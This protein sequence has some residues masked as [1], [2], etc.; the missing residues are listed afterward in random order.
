[1]SLTS[2]TTGISDYATRRAIQQLASKL[3]YDASPTF[4]GLTISGEALSST[5][6][7]QWRTAYSWGDHAGLYD[8]IGTASGEI[9]DHEST[10]DHTLLHNPVTLGT[11]N[12]LTLNDQELSLPTTA[13]PTL[14]GLTLTGM[15]G[16]V[17]TTAGVFSGS[18]TLDDMADGTNY[19]RVAATE[20]SSGVYKN[21]TTTVKGIASFSSTNFSVT[22][23]AVSLATGGGLTHNDLGSLQGGTTGEYYHFTSADYAK[24][25]NWDTAYGWGDHAG[26]YDAAGTAAGEVGTHESTYDH[27]LLHSPVTLDALTGITL[28]GQQL[29]YTAGYAI[30]TTA[31]QAEWDSA[32]THKT[33][34]DAINGLVSC[35]GSGAYTAKVIGTDVQAYDADLTA[36]AALTPTDGNIIVGDGSTWVAESDNTARTSLGLGTTDSPTFTSLVLTTTAGNPLYAGPWAGRPDPIESHTNIYQSIYCGNDGENVGRLR[37]G[38][39]HNNGFLQWN[40][41]WS[42][43]TSLK[44]DSTK[45]SWA[46]VLEGN[47]DNFLVQRAPV[48][49]NT[50]ATILTIRGRDACLKCSGGGIFAGALAAPNVLPTNTLGS[51]SLTNPSLT[52]GTS[53]TATNDCKLINNRAEFLYSS[54]AASTLTQASGTMAVPGV[55]SRWYSFTYTAS[56]TLLLPTLT[57][58]TSFAESAVPLPTEGTHTVYFKAAASPGDFVISATLTEGQRVYLDTFSLKEVT[59]TFE[60]GGKI[61]TNDKFNVNGTDGVTQAASAGKVCD[62]TALAGGI[63]TAQTQVTYIADGSHSLSGITSIT[64]INGRITAMA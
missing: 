43:V 62:V 22:D 49:S 46:V 15:S 57:I 55:A 20:L 27:S 9:D 14:A 45:P 12:G 3:N 19:A 16:V 11:A 44:M 23:G 48:E 42:G 13:T 33:T 64:T 8:T 30:P 36:I 50:L 63:A 40:R 21:A 39:N 52:S 5:L 6:I 18:A 54:G 26:L 31:K 7:T 24:I 32:Y 47:S 51:E 37:V 38:S 29:S 10:Y 53:W 34:E 61:R 60:A 4:A 35:D 56:S 28:T 2:L 41:Y 59:G 25:A 17:K 1:M 58:T